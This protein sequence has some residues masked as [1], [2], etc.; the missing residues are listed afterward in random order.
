MS[1]KKPETAQTRLKNPFGFVRGQS[2]DDRLLLILE[3]WR[4][5]RPVQYEAYQKHIEQVAQ[6]L[7]NASGMSEGKLMRYRSDIP[8]Q[9]YVVIR[10]FMPGFLDVPENMLRLEKLL[11]GKH[12]RLPKKT[13]QPR[14][15]MYED[16]SPDSSSSGKEVSA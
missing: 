13:T 7:H 6:S 4:Q 1:S 5:C 9:L 8:T 14:W 15:R 12:L 2:E 3:T 10:R 16:T 11:M